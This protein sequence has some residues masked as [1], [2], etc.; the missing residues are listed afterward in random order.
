MH[1]RLRH[2]NQST[3]QTNLSRR[4]GVRFWGKVF[5]TR[6]NHWE[7]IQEGKRAGGRITR[8]SKS[9]YHHCPYLHFL[10]SP[11]LDAGK[12][13]IPPQVGDLDNRPLI[14]PVDHRILLE[15][16]RD[17]YP[18]GRGPLNQEE[19]IRRLCPKPSKRGG[20]PH[21]VESQTD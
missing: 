14:T 6:S 21:Y 20:T 2:G 13:T 9:S 18:I 12:Y 8:H 15:S 3:V 1:P 11:S 5:Q 16:G 17:I 7:H 4:L 19:T 10:S